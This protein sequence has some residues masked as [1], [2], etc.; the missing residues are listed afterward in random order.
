MSFNCDPVRD[1]EPV[2]DRK[3]EVFSVSV[4]AGLNEPPSDL[5]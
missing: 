3:Y 1:I 2:S 4:E 5:R